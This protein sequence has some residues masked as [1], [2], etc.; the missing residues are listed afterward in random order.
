MGK[1]VAV[2]MLLVMCGYAV[3]EDFACG[4][5][6]KLRVYMQSIDPSK[7][8]AL[9]CTVIAKG[10]VAQQR[11]VIANNPQRYL[12]VENGLV[13]VM[14]T[15]QKNAVDA[16]IAAKQAVV[17]QLQAELDGQDICSQVKLE[18]IDTKFAQVQAVISTDVNAVSNI[19]T[20][21]AAMVTI[22]QELVT[23][24][25]KLARC[26]AASRQLRR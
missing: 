6:N 23:V 12:I 20:A 2:I 11:G 19:A 9:D 24:T 4:D 22:A 18:D 26:L 17:D 1:V 13:A 7:V 14:S 10:N 16:A 5:V 21:K 15:A 3:A 8:T 25:R